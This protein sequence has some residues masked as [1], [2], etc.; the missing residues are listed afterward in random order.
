MLASRDSHDTVAFPIELIPKDSYLRKLLSDEIHFPLKKTDNG[1]IIVNNTAQELE[2]LKQYIV[3]G[4]VSDDAS[5]LVELL[6]YYGVYHL[7]TTYPEDFMRIK[8]KEDWYRN[9]LYNVAFKDSPIRDNEYNLIRLDA[10]I[11]QKF[12]LVNLLHYLYSRQIYGGKISNNMNVDHFIEKDRLH[13]KEIIVP[14][15]PKK[16]LL[17]HSYPRYYVQGKEPEL[18]EK[19]KST[20]QKFLTRD[21]EFGHSL[22]RESLRNRRSGAQSDDIWQRTIKSDYKITYEN[23]MNTLKQ[24]RLIEHLTKHGL[25]NN[26]LLAGGSMLNNV[27]KC[28]I[29][30]DYDLFLYGLTEDQANN[31]LKDLINSLNIMYIQRS[32]NAITIIS[33]GSE[34]QIILRL[35]QTK[36]EILQSFDVDSCCVGYDGTHILITPR[37]LYAI[38]NMINMFD[39]DRM[40]PSYE[41]RLAKYMT[42]GFSVYVPDFTWLKVNKNEILKYQ[43]LKA[44]ICQKIFK[45]NRKHRKDRKARIAEILANSPRPPPLTGLEIL[46]YHY[47]HQVNPSTV[48]ARSDYCNKGRRLD[49]KNASLPNIGFEFGLDREKQIINYT[50]GLKKIKVL[51]I[52]QVFD[53]DL[54]GFV[55]NDRSKG[56]NKSELPPLQLKLSKTLTWKVISP[57]E[58]ATSTFHR[59]VVNDID[60]WYQSRF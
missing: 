6:D 23:I 44:E 30:T 1:A 58:Q 15:I 55:Y 60:V 25:W 33:N 34:I 56:R 48:K 41:Y 3:A 20:N 12:E 16:R 59:L 21:A 32:E 22:I 54:A 4:E 9:N 49:V 13:E 47:Y 39:F 46:I 26:L 45:V 42:R 53:L 24:N 31:K 35:Y 50:I 27:I 36:A 14:K 52:D 57:G 38:N 29:E 43:M 5:K 2:M 40:S 51:P 8:L 37:C 19:I 18:V 28:E 17:L 10:T 7:K 11:V